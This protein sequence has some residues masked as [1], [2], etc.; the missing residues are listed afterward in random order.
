MN[1]LEEYKIDTKTQVIGGKPK[2]PKFGPCIRFI[3]FLDKKI[4]NEEIELDWTKIDVS[5]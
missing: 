4:G 1:N 3:G 5:L 2:L